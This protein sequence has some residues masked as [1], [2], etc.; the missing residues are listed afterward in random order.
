MFTPNRNRKQNH[1]SSKPEVCAAGSWRFQVIG[2][3]SMESR[4][5]SWTKGRWRKDASPQSIQDEQ[6]LW[7]RK[8]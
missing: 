8:D 6:K 7:S 1:V 4:H 3:G 2:E 5:L